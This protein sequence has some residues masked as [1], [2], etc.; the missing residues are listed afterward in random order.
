MEQSFLVMCKIHS[1][2]KHH[3][4]DDI[5]LRHW[6]QAGDKKD[7]L[8]M[9]MVSPHRKVRFTV[10]NS[11][12]AVLTHERENHLRAGTYLTGSY[13]SGGSEWGSDPPHIA[14]TP[15]LRLR[16]G[17]RQEEWVRNFDSDYILVDVSEMFM[18]PQ[19]YGKFFTCLNEMGH[20]VVVT[21]L[22][23]QD[24]EGE[25]QAAFGSVDQLICLA[26]KARGYVGP[27]SIYSMATCISE[28]KAFLLGEKEGSEFLMPDPWRRKVLV[29]HIS[30]EFLIH[31][32]YGGSTLK[33]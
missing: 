28:R 19:D 10:R 23:D 12:P 5:V 25:Y 18:S 1:V 9:W 4:E 24:L 26:A 6:I 2:L 33:S 14:C 22:Q 31:N 13:A 7:F 17:K 3:P 21:G 8:E 29:G 32:M 27:F 20:N 30:P 15:W 16:F 11:I